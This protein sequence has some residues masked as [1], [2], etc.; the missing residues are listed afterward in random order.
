MGLE[1]MSVIILTNVLECYIW[2]L[3]MRS[4]FNYRVNSTAQR[5]GMRTVILIFMSLVNC[6]GNVPVNLTGTVFIYMIS[7][8]YL[9]EGNRRQLLYFNII[10]I[11]IVIFCEDIVIGAGYGGRYIIP[12]MNAGKFVVILAAKLFAILLVYAVIRLM[13]G[14]RQNKEASVPSRFCCVRRYPFC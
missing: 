1:E 10:E 14:R 6:V 2:N 11:L 13:Q 5:I 8:L 9:F 7:A 4:F 3:F 12:D